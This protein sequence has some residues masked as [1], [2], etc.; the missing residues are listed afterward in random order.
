MTEERDRPAILVVDQ[1]QAMFF[2][3]RQNMK[4]VTAAELAPPMIT[5][6]IVDEVLVPP[7]GS[8]APDRC[9]WR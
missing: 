1:R 2:G 7:E 4:S 6:W 5:K 8:A 3:S 9:S